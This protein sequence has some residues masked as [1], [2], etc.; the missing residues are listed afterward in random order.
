MVQYP[1]KVKIESIEEYSETKIY[2]NK[3]E[4]RNSNVN[5]DYFDWSAEIFESVT[6]RRE[7]VY[8]KPRINRHTGANVSWY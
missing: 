3:P 7:L 4:L 5:A 1:V 8:D 6:S 2:K